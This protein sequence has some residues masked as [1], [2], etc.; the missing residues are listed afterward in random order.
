MLEWPFTAHPANIDETPS[1][2]VVSPAEIARQLATLKAQHVSSQFPDDVILGADTL[3]E[4]SGIIFGKPKDLD[5]ARAML[6]KLS[7]RTHKVFTGVCLIGPDGIVHADHETTEVT[8]S[9]IDE[10]DLEWYVG[11]RRTLDKAGGYGIQDTGAVFVESIRGDFFNVMGLP[12]QLVFK[13]ITQLFPELKTRLCE[14]V[15]EA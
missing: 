13:M 3:V 14:N 10:D 4:L 2:D 8:M 7:G 15:I 12:L 6:R 9:E 5:D 1:D 11:S